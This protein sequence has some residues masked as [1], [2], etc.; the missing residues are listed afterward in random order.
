MRKLR[1]SWKI[2]KGGAA[3]Q[4]IVTQY[5]PYVK[6]RPR[7]ELGQE[8]PE[9]GRFQV[10]NRIEIPKSEFTY[11]IAV[12]KIIELDEK[13]RPF[14]IYADAGHGEYQIELLRK[15]L[16]DKVNRV[17]LGSSEEVKDP[18]SREMIKMPMKPFIVNQTVL[19]LERGKLM[20]PSKKKDE[21]LSRQMT[22]YQ[23]VKYSPKTGEATYS[24][25]DEHALDALMFTL[26]GFIKDKPELANTITNRSYVQSVTHI[27]KKTLDPFKIDEEKNTDN[28]LQSTSN[29][30]RVKA[31]QLQQNS[32]SWGKRGSRNR[33]PSRG[34]W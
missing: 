34:S 6:Q 27:K 21:T 24:D 26:Y 7:P 11:D 5:N 25:T 3:T 22:N 10:I 1:S 15:A 8:N 14:G 29:R 28:E 30:R 17:H 32:I 12:N 13:Y 18:Y 31:R 23:V 16:G 9:L 2:T 19:L 4:I 33:L 20:I